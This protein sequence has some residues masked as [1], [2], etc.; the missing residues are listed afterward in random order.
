MRTRRLTTTAA[1]VR[2]GD[3]LCDYQPSHVMRDADIGSM[4]VQYV[5]VYGRFVDIATEG[6]GT[7]RLTYV[8]ADQPVSVIRTYPTN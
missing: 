4:S 1:R 8:L 5:T 7:E 3:V 2:T 6:N